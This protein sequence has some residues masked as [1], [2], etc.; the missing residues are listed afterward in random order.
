MKILVAMRTGKTRDAFITPRAAKM[1][2]ELGTVIW[3][4]SDRVLRDEALKEKLKGVEVCITGWGC[5]CFDKDILES[6]DSLRLIAHTGGSVATLVTEDVYKKGIKVISGNRIYA[7]SVAEG[8]IAYML[9]SLR[10]IPYYSEMVQQNKWPHEEYTTEGLLDQTVGLVGFGMVAK[11]LARM[12]QPFRVKLKAYDPFVADEVFKEYG[13]E[14]AT[15]EEVLTT[16]KIVSVHAAK[17]EGTY[18]MI[19]KD[20]LEK[21]PDGTILVNTAR[22]SIFDEE[23]LAEELQKG[24]F[25]AILDVFETE[26]LPENSKLRGLKNVILIPHMAGPTADRMERVTLEL[27]EDIKNLYQGKPL[28]HE[29]DWNYAKAMTR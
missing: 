1:L 22:G 20:L 19:G 7:E 10:D 21:I 29:I 12:I 8:T 9:A 14:K 25:K 15:L 23:A 2:E 16:C 11:Y 6:A 5:Q 27:I 17:T 3:N 28:K 18:H 24:R 26:P 13:V 4:E